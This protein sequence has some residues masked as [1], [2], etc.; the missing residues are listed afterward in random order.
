MTEADVDL[1]PGERILWQDRP[2]RHS[3]FR[4]P[5]ALLIPF[6]ILWFG[7]AVF[8]EA[9]VLAART[10]GDRP[11][12]VFV[13]LWGLP[14]VLIGLYLVVGR[15]VVRAIASRRTRYVL[16]DLR[17]LVIGGLS[18]KRTTSSYLRSLPPPVVTEQPDRSGSLAF[19][20]FPGVLD[21]FNRRNG[22]RGWASEPSNTPV[23]WHIS[24]VRRVRDLVA[25]AQTERDRSADFPR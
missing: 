19:G 4:A 20:A 11:P 24:D 16:T 3:L 23:L 8:W 13:V 21:A 7:F 1:L 2:R 25:A 17:I 12:P 18:G 6:S 22:L 15:F 10:V 5:D 9:S 14:F